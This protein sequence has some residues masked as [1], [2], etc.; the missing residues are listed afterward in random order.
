M[1]L[2]S[3]SGPLS[4]DFGTKVI[5]I[6]ALASASSL[7]WRNASMVPGEYDTF[8][9]GFITTDDFTNADILEATYP[10]LQRG[11]MVIGLLIPP[12]P[13]LLGFLGKGWKPCAVTTLGRGGSD[14]TA[15]T[16]GKP[17]R[18]REIQVWKDVDGF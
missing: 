5:S 1:F 16:I 15:K 18:V 2:R 17:L 9:I 13:I 3:K 14:L 10:L 12:F 11:C 4:F 6:K 7:S 8:E